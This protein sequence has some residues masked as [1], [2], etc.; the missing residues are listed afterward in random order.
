MAV[1]RTLFIIK[2]DGIKRY[3]TNLILMKITNS[4]LTILTRRRAAI[5]QEQAE[6]L[7]I[8][9]KGK[10]FYPGLVKFITS[11]PVML[12][13]IE[14]DDA[15]ARIRKLMGATDPRKADAGT[16][17][18]DNKEDEVI[19]EDG[20]IKNICHGSDSPDNARYEISIFFNEADLKKT[21]G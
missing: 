1:E 16:I 14:G 7:Y 15:I 21:G 9:H 12:T 2:P 13:V 17:R 20:I 18:G 19:N 8:V 10:P 5:T 11:G 3:L 6:K 4:G